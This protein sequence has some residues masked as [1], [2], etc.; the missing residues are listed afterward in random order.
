MTELSLLAG[1]IAERVGMCVGD[2]LLKVNGDDVMTSSVEEV[3]KL[4]PSPMSPMP[5]D[6]VDRLSADELRDLIAYLLGKSQ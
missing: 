4:E 1:G 3:A 2:M 5:K 6:L